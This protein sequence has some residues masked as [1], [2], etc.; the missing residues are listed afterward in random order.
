MVGIVGRLRFAERSDVDT[1]SCQPS[2]LVHLGVVRMGRT[3]W[4]IGWSIH[5]L[6]VSLA[7]PTLRVVALTALKLKLNVRR[8]VRFLHN[9]SSASSSPSPDHP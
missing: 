6:T 1:T 3:S 9:A 7:S 4:S 2:L 8:A 5:W